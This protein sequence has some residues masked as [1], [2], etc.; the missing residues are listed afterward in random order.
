MAYKCKVGDIVEFTFGSSPYWDKAIGSV[1]IIIKI[2]P[3]KN[4][5]GKHYCYLVRFI[6]KT[7]DELLKSDIYMSSHNFEKR[8]HAEEI[9]QS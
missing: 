7:D 8:G 6:A 9:P 3:N 1:G 2:V 4:H 5:G